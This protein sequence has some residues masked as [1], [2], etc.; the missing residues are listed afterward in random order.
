MGMLFSLIPQELWILILLGTAFAIIF[1]LVNRGVIVSIIVLMLV[2]CIVGPII[3]SLIS[4][5]PSWISAILMIVFGLTVINWIINLIFGKRT[6]GHLT[7]LLL[8]D[9]M[10]APF[11]AVRFLLRGR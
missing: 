9:I 7:A 3:G 6:G 1:G 2:L 4:A 11:R 10:L 8:H 5:L